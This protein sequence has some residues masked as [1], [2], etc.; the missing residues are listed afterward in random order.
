MPSKHPD[1]NPSMPTMA[2]NTFHH[3]NS[4]PLPSASRG[5]E[6]APYDGPAAADA[7]SR[8]VLAAVQADSPNLRDRLE[9]LAQ[10]RDENRQLRQELAYI[11]KLQSAS[12]KLLEEVRVT[13]REL[14]TAVLEFRNDQKAIDRE[15]LQ[16]T[17]F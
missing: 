17:R 3:W 11:H 10:L 5:V 7:A 15:F 2:G 8:R 12:R 14:R 6:Q 16:E 1:S 4:K 9:D 13:S